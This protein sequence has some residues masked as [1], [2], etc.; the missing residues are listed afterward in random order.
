MVSDASQDLVDPATLIR[1]WALTVLAAGLLGAA[2][3]A[4]LVGRGA[5]VYE[6]SVVVLV[7]PIVPDS[8]LLEGTTDLARTYGEILES[9][10]VIRQ[11]A[12]GS[13]VRTGQVDVSASAGRD[14]AT[15]RVRVRTPS[16]SATTTV[17][18]NLVAILREV[19]ADN[20][21]DVRNPAFGTLDETVPGEPASAEPADPL[22]PTATFPIGSAITVIDDG[23]DGV[24]D[25]SLGEAEG[26][27]LGAL[28][29]TLLA[30][31]LA[32]GAETRRADDPLSRL[33]VERFGTDLG[34]LGRVPILRMLIRRSARVV[35]LAKSRQ[36]ELR[37]TAEALTVGERTGPSTVVFLAAPS[38]HPAYL[39]AVIQLCSGFSSPPT[40]ID[41]MGVLRDFFAPAT[42][43]RLNSERFSVTVERRAV[44]E[45][46]V[47]HGGRIPHD[48][49]S[50]RA[51][52]E[53]LGAGVPV[54]FVFAPVDSA[55]SAWLWWASSS[56]RSVALVRTSDLGASAASEF[57]ARI[58]LTDRPI[59]GAISLRRRFATGRVGTVSVVE[60]REYSPTSSF[61]FVTEL[62]GT[63]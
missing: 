12:E 38:S 39:R 40:V 18:V 2:L 11:A 26:A 57:T 46:V 30:A 42:F 9:T 52:V 5:A 20:R 10:G 3:G 36:R 51:N 13:G 17:A 32:L 35:P 58:Q 7:G 27:V 19:V 28:V 34:R 60:L 41:P 44:A 25:N 14:S 4:V 61:R 24:S 49:Q 23:V 29:G 59:D 54:V 48:T 22:N 45:L 15:L 1:R 37:Y 63:P 53:A 47:P 21:A 16:R 33:V 6:T 43:R 62:T 50:A 31:A 56:D 55:V 8:D